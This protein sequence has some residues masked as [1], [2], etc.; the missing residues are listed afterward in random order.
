MITKP[1]DAIN[2]SPPWLY[3]RPCTICKGGKG[4]GQ[5]WEAEHRYSDN[6][7]NDCR[8]TTCPDNR[9]QD[10][11]SG[12]FHSYPCGKP[13]SVKA[14]R[15]YGDKPVPMCPMHAGIAK[16]RITR[17]NKQQAQWAAQS[18]EHDRASAVRKEV[19][20]RV[21]AAGAQDATVAFDGRTVTL[22]VAE[23]FR[24]MTHDLLSSPSKCKQ[25]DINAGV[26]LA[27]A[28]DHDAAVDA[29]I[30]RA[31]RAAAGSENPVTWILS[32]DL[33]GQSVEWENLVAALRREIGGKP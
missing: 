19:Q 2:D 25:C 4:E 10:R 29:A 24:P 7:G 33:R 15:K 20:G 17:A 14:L 3:D 12:S 13:A 28:E 22:P 30:A 27:F 11:I 16:S 8:H 9:C 31:V 23:F 6:S 5:G 32:D 18:T 26:L 21:D 1:R